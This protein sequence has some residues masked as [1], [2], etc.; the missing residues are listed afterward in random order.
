MTR[1]RTLRQG[2]LTSATVFDDGQK[3]TIHG[4]LDLDWFWASF[5]DKLDRV[6][7]ESV[8]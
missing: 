4:K 7:N 3:D 2:L 8:N 6:S 5:G 1:V